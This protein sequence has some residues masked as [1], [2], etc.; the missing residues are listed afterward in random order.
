M[1]GPLD[2]SDYDDED[3]DSFDDSYEAETSSDDNTSGILLDQ[4]TLTTT[5]SYTTVLAIDEQ[6]EDDGSDTKSIT[7]ATGGMLQ[8]SFIEQERNSSMAYLHLNGIRNDESEEPPISSMLSDAL[9]E[10]ERAEISGEEQEEELQVQM[11]EEMTR[12]INDLND[13]TL[14]LVNDKELPP[15]LT[16]N[17]RDVAINSINVSTP[18]NTLTPR[19]M[20]ETFDFDISTTDKEEPIDVSVKDKETIQS[21]QGP[22]IFVTESSNKQQPSPSS[23]KTSTK[24]AGIA[25]N[26]NND[27]MNLT[28]PELVSSSSGDLLVSY[29]KEDMLASSDIMLDVTYSRDDLLAE[30]ELST[31][32]SG[33]ILETDKW[34][35]P[36]G[37]IV[38]E[39]LTFLMDKVSIVQLLMDT[40]NGYS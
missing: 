27:L 3:D 36:I 2:D 5:T 28:M 21:I 7:D 39:K 9:E 35:L 14:K 18:T 15:P 22:T 13:G 38:D 10:M 20:D 31:S 25:S 6:K 16:A 29:S 37:T 1:F 24:S 40:L 12:Q 11:E 32:Q 8:N 26:D 33:S 4:S 19:Q 23:S 34:E 30:S 17:A